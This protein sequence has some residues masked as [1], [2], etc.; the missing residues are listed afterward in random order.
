MP[1]R[2]FASSDTSPV[3][4]LA[5]RDAPAITG[6]AFPAFIGVRRADLHQ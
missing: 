2:C 3:T 6:D 4:E 5:A 1:F